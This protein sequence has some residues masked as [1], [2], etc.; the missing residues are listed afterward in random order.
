MVSGK[1]LKRAAK[2]GENFVALPEEKSVECRQHIKSH[3]FNSDND[4]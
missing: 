4:N 3:S 1:V 2:L